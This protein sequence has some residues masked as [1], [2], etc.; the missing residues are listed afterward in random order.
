MTTRFRKDSDA[1]LDY[2]VNWA[3]YLTALGGDTIVSAQA[4]ATSGI[5]I[6]SESYTST[7]HTFWLG[8]GTINT[9]Y[10]ITSRI[11]TTAG[12]RDDKTI[13]I[14]VENR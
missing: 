6:L 4:I 5:S 12:R 14:A 2:R 7:D 10:P 9:T 13:Y 11:W 1:I 3:T 8:G